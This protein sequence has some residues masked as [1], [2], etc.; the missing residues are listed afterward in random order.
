MINRNKLRGL[1]AENSITQTELAKRLGISTNAFNM[2]INGKTS[3]T[4]TEIKRIAEI[5][6]I[7]LSFL[8]A[9]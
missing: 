1:M 2:K 7:E 8:F 5:L 6:K 9:V 3:F 4:E